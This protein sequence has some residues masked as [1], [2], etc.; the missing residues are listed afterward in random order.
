MACLDHP[1]NKTI[2]GAIGFLDVFFGV[3]QFVFGEEGARVGAVG[4]GL[5][6]EH[7]NF[8]R[9]LAVNDQRFIGQACTVMPDQ[10]ERQQECQGKHKKQPTISGSAKRAPSPSF[11]GSARHSI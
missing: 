10:H 7:E 5:G 1:V 8:R 11:S 6:A 9:V 4:T 2:P 3:G